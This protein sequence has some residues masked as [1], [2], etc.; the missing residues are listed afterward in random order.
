MDK[1]ELLVIRKNV[2][3]ILLNHGTKCLCG[4]NEWCDGC[5]PSSSENKLFSD[6]MD[7]FN[8]MINKA[9]EDEK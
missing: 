3:T 6:M 5:S 8:D 9:K 2:A 7:Y 1:E 4:H